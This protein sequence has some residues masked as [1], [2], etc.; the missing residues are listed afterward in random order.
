MGSFIKSSVQ[1]GMAVENLRVQMNALLGSVEEG[2]KAFEKMTEFAA[3]IPFSL[4]QIQAGSGSLAAAADNADELR[5]LMQI[6]GNIAAQFNIPFEMAAENVQRALSAGAASADLFQQKGVN[7]FM[8]FQA[9]VSY[10]S[11][12]T[13]KVLQETFGTGGS[14]DGAMANFAKT[15]AGVASMFGDAMFKMQGHLRRAA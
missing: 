5:E 6:T 10:S 13:A 4:D 7:A 14:S 8:G 12:E 15:S 11:A 2:G 1:T 9:G 3:G